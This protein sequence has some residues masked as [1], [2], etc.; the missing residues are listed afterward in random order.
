MQI[1]HRVMVTTYPN[2]KAELA[3]LGVAH[4]AEQGGVVFFQCEEANS[5]WPKIVQWIGAVGASQ[6]VTTKFSAEEVS[7]ARW[8][9]LEPEWHFGYPQP[10]EHEFGYL[11]A[12]YDLSSYCEECGTGCRQKLPFQMKG[13]PKWGRRSILQ[14]NWVFDEYFVTPQVWASIFKPLG[15]ACLPVLNKRGAELDTV[16]QL[17]A[18]TEVNIVLEGLKA[19][20]CQACS[21]VK[22]EPVTRGPFPPLCE[23]LDANMARTKQYFGGGARAFKGVVISQRLSR[24]LKSEGV[25]GASVR[26]VADEV[27]RGQQACQASDGV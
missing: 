12:A 27:W 20:L 24:A 10:N 16:V 17:V 18:E 13:E 8:L 6:N 19:T 9:E 25:R 1:I 23:Q 11:K 5:F 22:Y 15:I 2:I 3:S 4:F 7:S 21:R 14:L 26:P